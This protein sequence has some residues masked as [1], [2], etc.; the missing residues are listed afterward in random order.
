MVTHPH[1]AN[2]AAELNA[3]GS[4]LIAGSRSNLELLR[5][6]DSTI[7]WLVRLREIAHA[8]L[9]Y[10]G[11]LIDKVRNCTLGK[12]IDAD[13]KISD[14]FEEAELELQK[15]HGLL[16]KKQ[17]HGRNARELTDEQKEELIGEYEQTIESVSQLHDTLEELRWAMLDHDG[18]ISGPG[19]SITSPEELASFLQ[20]L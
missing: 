3:F 20:K 13:D 12:E 4:E 8:N 14:T 17:E 10:G 18:R 7:G 1:F 16:R 19:Q 15:L 6:F 2:A 9:T 5:K 11:N